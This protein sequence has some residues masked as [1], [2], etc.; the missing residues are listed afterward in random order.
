MA[1]NNVPAL[2][3]LQEACAV[4]LYATRNRYHFKSDAHETVCLAAA[5]SRLAPLNTV[6]RYVEG[7]AVVRCRDDRSGRLVFG[8]F[9]RETLARLFV[10]VA[11]AIMD[12]N[13]ETR[14]ARESLRAE[15]IEETN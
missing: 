10:G 15:F 7:R 3:I 14:G 4:W 5:I 8:Q 13:L 6:T 9:L 11:C 2:D 1:Q 12:Q